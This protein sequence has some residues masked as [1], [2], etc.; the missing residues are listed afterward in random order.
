MQLD[1]V[2]PEL[3]R[4]ARGVRVGLCHIEHFG[5]AGFVRDL[6]ASQSDAGRSVRWRIGERTAVRSAAHA[7]MP[8]LWSHLAAR[9]MDGV[10]DTLPS[11]QR[12]FSPELRNVR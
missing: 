4:I 9:S 8:E 2:E 7:L 3:L 11:R 1:A 12:L 10:N 5:F 6:L